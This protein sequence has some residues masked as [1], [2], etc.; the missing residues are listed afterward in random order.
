[1]LLHGPLFDAQIARLQ[2]PV[3]DMGRLG[4]AT[5][6]YNFSVAGV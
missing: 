3:R 4:I 6:G 1:V 5:M 2:Q